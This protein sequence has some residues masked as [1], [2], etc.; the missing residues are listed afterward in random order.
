MAAQ[1]PGRTDN[2]IKNY[3]NTRLKKKLLGNKQRKMNQ[4]TTRV[5]NTNIFPLPP[6]YQQFQP[7]PPLVFPPPPLTTTTSYHHH[8]ELEEPPV[9]GG[10]QELI[11]PLMPSLQ[12]SFHDMSAATTST[13]SSSSSSISLINSPTTLL[14]PTYYYCPLINNNNNNENSFRSLS[15]SLGLIDDDYDNPQKQTTLEYLDD[16]IFMESILQTR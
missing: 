10:D 7:P 16:G 5:N 9:Y 4:R 8:Q 6:S 14:M 11:M 3:W 2:D 15:S 1:L 13:S 12:P